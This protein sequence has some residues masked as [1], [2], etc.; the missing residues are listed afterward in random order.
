VII[1]FARVFPSIETLIAY[2]L[3]FMDVAPEREAPLK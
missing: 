1:A 3:P 2:Y